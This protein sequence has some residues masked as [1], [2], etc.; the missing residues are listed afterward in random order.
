MTSKQS[1]IIEKRQ[2][3]ISLGALAK[4]YAVSRAANQRVEKRAA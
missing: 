4:E 3:G 2:Q 1:D